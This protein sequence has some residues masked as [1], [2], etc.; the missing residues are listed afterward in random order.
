MLDMIGRHWR[1]DYP[2]AR[3]FWVSGMLGSLYLGAFYVTLVVGLPDG[4]E[5]APG[6]NATYL[7]ASLLFG[8]WLGV[9]L[10]RSANHHI[11]QTG[12]Q[13]W[14]RIDQLIVVIGFVSLADNIWAAFID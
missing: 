5:S 6:W 9:G 13:F 1:G 11:E 8:I 14:A 2:L 12:R 10:W 7:V 4:I 3:S